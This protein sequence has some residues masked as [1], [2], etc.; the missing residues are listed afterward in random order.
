MSNKGQ[1]IQETKSNLKLL[2]RENEHEATAAAPEAVRV[3]IERVEPQNAAIV[4]DVEHAEI[5]VRDGKRL[6]ADKQPLVFR[7]I[8]VL[9]TQ[10]GTDFVWAELE[11]TLFGGRVDVFERSSVLE[12]QVLDT[13]DDEVHIHLFGSHAEGGFAEDVVGPVTNTHALVLHGLTKAVGVQSRTDG[14]PL[15]DLRVGRNLG[16]DLEDLLE[17]FGVFDPPLFLLLGHLRKALGDTRHELGVL[18]HGGF[19]FR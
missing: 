3:V 5:A 15:P 18:R 13:D 9:Q 17:P 1:K 8:L 12:A 10:L 11:A 4:R 6:H 7:L 14:D 16:Q 19:S 2:A